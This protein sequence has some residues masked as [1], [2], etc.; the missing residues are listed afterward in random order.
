[1]DSDIPWDFYV[2]GP[3][4][5]TGI[6]TD[7]RSYPRNQVQLAVD[8]GFRARWVDRLVIA[9]NGQAYPRPFYVR[10]PNAA[11]FNIPSHR[12]INPNNLYEF[13]IIRNDQGQ[14]VFMPQGGD[15]GPDRVVF[16]GDTGY[17]AG[18]FTHRG[19][20]NNN[21]HQ[22]F[23]HNE[24][25]NDPR[26]DNDFGV[27]TLD[28]NPFPW[29]NGGGGSNLPYKRTPT[30]PP[31]S[32]QTTFDGCPSSNGNCYCYNKVTVEGYYPRAAALKAINQAC[33]DWNGQ[34]V[35]VSPSSSNIKTLSTIKKIPL[36]GKTWVIEMAVWQTLLSGSSVTT[37]DKSRCVQALKNA[38]DD[39]QTKTTSKKIGG[40]H[41]IYISGGSQQYLIHPGKGNPA[42]A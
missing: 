40:E 15:Q 25:V 22:A 16:D 30:N 12:Q 36:N 38:M 9:Q 17:F 19:E 41:I 20:V 32:F 37:V 35:P 10:G 3:R 2:C 29:F 28:M 1:M 11:N 42:P 18:V 26:I 4:G 23:G 33:N 24:D 5:N 27:T 6:H 39:C 34:K 8:A 31:A 14:F 7:T 21:F 13:P